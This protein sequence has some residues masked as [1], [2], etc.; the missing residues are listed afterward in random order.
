M[1]EQTGNYR[2]GAV[3]F[4]NTIPLIDDPECGESDPYSKSREPVQIEHGDFLLEIRRVEL[5][6]IY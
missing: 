1:K 6:S 5:M 2:L 3:S 4:L